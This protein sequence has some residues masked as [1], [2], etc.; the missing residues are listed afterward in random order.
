MGYI[1]KIT[2]LI[3]GKMYIGQTKRSIDI[4]WKE[5]LRSKDDSPIHKAFRKYGIENFKIETLEECADELL[6]EKEIY[7]IKQYNSYNGHI[8]YN[9][10]PGGESNAQG[11]INWIKSHP[12]EVKNNL[13]KAREIAIK[14]FE[15]NP[16]LKEKRE[17][18]RMG[19]YKKYIEENKEEWLASQREKLKKARQTLQDQYKEDPEKIINRAKENGKKASK[20][21]KQID[22]KTGE[23]IQVFESCSAAARYLGHEGGHTNI[24][25]ACRKSSC[26]AF[27]FKWAYV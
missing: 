15:D 18:L 26:S 7:Y 12:E 14:K 22:K 5:H 23:V 6:N 13:N 11:A 27:G 3:N 10:T 24:S 17:K 21:V 20:A 4:R 8:G 1:Y 19:G 2:N 9:A 16:E 25:K